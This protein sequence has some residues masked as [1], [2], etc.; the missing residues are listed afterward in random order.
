M[1]QLPN[2]QAPQLDEALTVWR[3]SVS[4]FHKAIDGI[5]DGVQPD[6]AHLE[7]LRADVEV[8]RVICERLAAEG[9]HPPAPD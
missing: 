7:K 5:S 9:N 6:P 4:D 2:K 8:T 1:T 3:A